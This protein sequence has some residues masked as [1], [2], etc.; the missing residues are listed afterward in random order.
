MVCFGLVWFG[1]IWLGV[2]WFSLVWF[3]LVR[4]G[5]VWLGFM[6]VSRSAI[7][8]PPTPPSVDTE[9]AGIE[10]IQHMGRNQ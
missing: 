9:G 5:L 6:A 7:G 2:V 8:T 10:V 4:F 1:L 3:G